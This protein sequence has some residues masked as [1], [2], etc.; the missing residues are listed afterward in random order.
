MPH[1]VHHNH[2]LH[3]H[4]SSA[5]HQGTSSNFPPSTSTAIVSRTTESDTFPVQSETPLAKFTTIL[6]AIS[7]FTG[8]GPQSTTS[9]IS[10]E[11]FSSNFSTSS[12]LTPPGEQYTWT[13]PIPLSSLD[14]LIMEFKTI[15]LPGMVVSVLFLIL[16]M[17]VC[18]YAYRLV[19]ANII[20]G[21]FKS[22]VLDF[23][24][25]GE[26]TIISWELIT[27]FQQYEIEVWTCFAFVSMIIKFYRFKADCVSCP[28]SHIQSRLKGFISSKHAIMRIV[29]Q[30]LGGSIFYRIHSRMWDL[31]LT[32]IHK[33]RSY[34]TSYGMCAAWLS[35]E[36]WIGFLYEFTGSLLCS[37]STTLIFDFELLP[38]MSIHVRI[39]LASTITICL[40]LTSFHHTGG[41]FQPMLAF[42]RTFGCVGI[43]RD[44]TMLDHVIVYWIG[45]SL[46]AILAMYI[47]PYV[48]ILCIKTCLKNKVAPPTEKLK[49][50]EEAVPIVDEHKHSI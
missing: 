47:T 1:V 11:A 10:T 7:N 36:T 21:L 24:S 9:P 5:S 37:I 3:F 44:V 20:P 2:S 50:I 19:L 40:V 31:G 48:K 23:I 25:A 28:Y 32:E 38:R 35:E 26:A 46:G 39:F 17:V 4:N 12:G 33:G 49:K 22:C 14:K 16:I 34:W 45:A 43:L 18:E 29:C 8:V 41:F 27:M 42:V 13:T 6:Q 30:F 15:Y